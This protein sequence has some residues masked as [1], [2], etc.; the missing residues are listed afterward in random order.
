MNRAMSF[1][2]RFLPL[3]RDAVEFL[4]SAATLGSRFSAP[5]VNKPFLLQPVETG[6]YR[7]DSDILF[8]FIQQFFTDGHPIG[9]VIEPQNH[10]QQQI[11][12]TSKEAGRL[13]YNCS[14]VVS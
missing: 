1:L 14:V 9:A 8:R 6:V 5:G 10:Q 11:L 2:K 12:E 7:A 13:H 3:R 4:G